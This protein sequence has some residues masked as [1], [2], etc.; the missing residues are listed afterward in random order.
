LRLRASEIEKAKK[1]LDDGVITQAEFNSTKDRDTDLT[2]VS[3]SRR[4]TSWP[5]RHH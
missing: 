4:T 3:T 2:R 5:R 1:L